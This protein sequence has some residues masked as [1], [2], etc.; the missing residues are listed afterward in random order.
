M[1]DEP[2]TPQNL[3]G[4]QRPRLNELSQQTTEDD[5]WDLDETPE[6]MPTPA[7]APQNPP[8]DSPVEA[9]R[10]AGTPRAPEAREATGGEAGPEALPAVP[11]R[12]DEPRPTPASRPKPTSRLTETAGTSGKEKVALVAS[13][14][15]ALGLA[16]WL[17]IGM[18]SGVPTTR[19][20]DNQP[21]LPAA[22]SF[23]TVATLET[24]WREP[25][26]EGENRDIARREVAMIPVV[27]LTL[28]DSRS[29]ALRVIFYDSQGDSVG[30]AVS[31]PFTGGQFDGTGSPTIEIA[32]T[33][34]F[35]DPGDFDAYRVGG[36]RWTVEIREGPSTNAP[37]REFKELLSA[38]ISSTRR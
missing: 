12:Q 5:L 1:P 32:A 6:P 37:G 24:F 29:G 3:P 34:G 22:G 18:F 8:A 15:V 38:P 17:V 35:T 26:R 30:D 11:A 33:D 21:E 9:E 13:G 10:G 28:D 4:R 25:I 7:A 23:T 31:Q 2:D 14:V 20:G 27:S 19:I 16:V 36:E